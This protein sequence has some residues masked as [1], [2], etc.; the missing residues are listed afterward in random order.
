ML[1]EIK[2]T[3]FKNKG[4]ELMLRSIVS[5]VSRWRPMPRIAVAARTGPYIH[6]ARL[7]L[8]QQ[9]SPGRLLRAGLPDVA[10]LVPA[11]LRHRYGMVLEREVDAILDANGFSYSSQWGRQ[12]TLRLA[13]S[14]R[15]WR[16]RGKKVVLLPQA[17]GPFDSPGMRESFRTV[18]ANADLVYARDERSYAYVMELGVDEGNVRVAPDFTHALPGRLPD[19][20]ELAARP[21]A[22]VPNVRVMEGGSVDRAAYLSLLGC[23]ARTLAGLGFSPFVLVH[24]S[25]TDQEIAEAL[26]R[27]MVPPLPVIHRHDPLEL[28]GIIGACEFVVGSRYHALIASLSQNV[29]VLAIEWS[30][31]YA[32]LLG[33]YGCRESVLSGSA[34]ADQA[35]QLLAHLA[36][37]EARTR[38]ARSLNECNARNRAATER[39]WSD[40]R[41]LLTGADAP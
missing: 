22:I 36:G 34:P 16:R 23:C 39:M 40:V 14:A 28:K 38:V 10:A 6:R 30:H 21:A 19:E 7:G 13:Q 4:A 3:G 12:S 17:L 20:V 31:K 9:V 29:P 15:M 11:G 26:A 41:T 37:D 2:G 18:I 33:E 5:E 1:I 25:G 35:A 32:A 27:S 24:D 8:Y